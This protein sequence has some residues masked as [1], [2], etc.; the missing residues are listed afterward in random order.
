MPKEN[1]MIRNAEL[2]SVLLTIEKRCKGLSLDCLHAKS[3][4]DEEK[5][6]ASGFIYSKNSKHEKK[7]GVESESK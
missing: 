6:G 1:E 7:V 3:A 5:T 2:P 4:N